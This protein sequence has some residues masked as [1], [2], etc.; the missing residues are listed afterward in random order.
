[1]G[2]S[3]FASANAEGKLTKPLRGAVSMEFRGNLIFIRVG[4]LS[5]LGVTKTFDVSDPDEEFGGSISV[6]A[7]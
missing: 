3:L 5:R 1:M 6:A 2:G 7:N 4:L